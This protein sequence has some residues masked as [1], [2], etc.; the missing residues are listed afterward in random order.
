MA[1]L[2]TL[3]EEFEEQLDICE[4]DSSLFPIA[5]S[6]DKIEESRKLAQYLLKSGSQIVHELRD[7]EDIDTLKESMD[8]FVKIADDPSHAYIRMILAYYNAGER[9]DVIKKYEDF[10]E[11]ATPGLMKQLRND[12]EWLKV[13]QVVGPNERLKN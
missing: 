2:E 12:S 5:P 3:I 11:I 1:D 6:M 10:A 8:H 9:E 7:Y 4:R 13:L